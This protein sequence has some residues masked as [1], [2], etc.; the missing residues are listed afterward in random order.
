MPDR[1]LKG[2]LA[3]DSRTRFFL[4]ACPH[5]TTPQYGSDFLGVLL[6]P[7]WD[8]VKPAQLAAMQLSRFCPLGFLFVW[9]EK[10]VLSEVVD[11]FVKAEYVY[12]E[13]LTWVHVAPN[14][15]AVEGPTAYTGRSHRT[16]LIFRRDVRSHPKGKEIEL[17]H[18][19]SPDVDVSIPQTGADGQLVSPEAAYLAIETLLPGGYTPGQKGRLLELWGHA[20]VSRPG[21]THVRTAA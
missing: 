6:N 21:W 1:C 15:R 20:E 14:N 5:H 3:A 8:S 10:E 2:E 7:P 17:R 4:A 11:V 12:V 19:R 13:N 9:V 18:Q 16:L